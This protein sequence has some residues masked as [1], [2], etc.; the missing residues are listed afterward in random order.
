MT[1]P[2]QTSVVKSVANKN[3]ISP[4]GLMFLP[5]GKALIMDSELF[6]HTLANSIVIDLVSENSLNK[7]AITDYSNESNDNN[8]QFE[9]HKVSR[10]NHKDIN[11]K[12]SQAN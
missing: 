11:R 4:Q 7:N 8:F 5:D 10:N 3:L 6:K 12:P 2:Q 9:E 1:T